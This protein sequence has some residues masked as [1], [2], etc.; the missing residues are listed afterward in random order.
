MIELRCYASFIPGDMVMYAELTG[1]CL[2]ASLSTG[3]AFTPGPTNNHCFGKPF[4]N[5]SMRELYSRHVSPV[6][7][8]SV[9][10]A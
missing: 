1:S 7:P 3:I 5:R 6:S 2:G 10:C 4:L 8:W 9:P